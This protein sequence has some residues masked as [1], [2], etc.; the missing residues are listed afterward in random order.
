MTVEPRIDVVVGA[1]S[2]LGAAL[3]LNI[4][5]SGTPTIMAARRV[6]SIRE[7]IAGSQQ[8]E[9]GVAQFCDLSDW[10]SV[11]EFVS[12]L[13]ATGVVGRLFLVAGANEPTLPSEP[14]ERCEAADRYVRMT[15]TSWVVLVD[16]LGRLGALDDRSTVVAVS[17]IAAGVPFAELSLYGAGKAA[18]E[19]WVRSRRGGGGPRWVVVRPGRFRSEFF[20]SEGGTPPL[21]FELAETILREVA[22]GSTEIS[23]G[24][25]RDRLGTGLERAARM[26]ATRIVRDASPERSDT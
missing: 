9:L 19:Q 1:S 6:S 25:A 24:G 23:L 8:A 18:L 11:L 13:A 16:E 4:L 20:P 7:L 3:G 14:V 10:S 5:G 17:S 26:A 22:A 15:F 12:K 2:G 21:P